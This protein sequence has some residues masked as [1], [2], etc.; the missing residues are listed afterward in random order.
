MMLAGGIATGDGAITEEM[1]KKKLYKKIKDS[2]RVEPEGA[3]TK[4]ATK[5]F[6][7]EGGMGLTTA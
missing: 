4:L 1:A 6:T 2:T 5:P 7:K 3:A